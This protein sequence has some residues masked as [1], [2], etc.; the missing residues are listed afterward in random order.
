MPVIEDAYKQ[1]WTTFRYHPVQAAL[2][3]YTGR[4]A[5]IVAGRRSGKT[6]LCRRKLVLQLPIK[7]PW[8]DPRYYFILPTYR[9]AEEVAWEKIKE[10]V[11]PAWIL[12]GGINNTKMTIK[13]VFGSKLLVAGADKPKR[14]EGVPSDFVM[15]DE[16]ADQQPGLFSRTIL[17]M[18]TERSGNC[19]RLGVPKKDGIGRMEFREFYQHG[20]QGLNQIASFHWVSADIL[21]PGEVELARA[22]LDPVEFAEQ[23]EAMWQDLGSSVY[24]NFG[25]VNLRDD[26]DYDPAYEIVVGCDFNVDPMCWTL[27][28]FIDGKLYVFDELFLRDANTPKTMDFLANKFH[29]HTAG[30]KFF[31]DATSKARKTNASRS[32]YVIIKNDARFGNK[33]VI[34]P[35]K[36]PSRRDRYASVNAAF[37]TA[38][39][40]TR[41]YVHTRCKR[42]I[43]DFNAVSYVEGTTDLEDYT[44][45]DLGHMSDALGYEVYGLMPIRVIPTSI[46]TVLSKTG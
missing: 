33:R 35:E 28:Q 25:Q 16:S 7:K 4:F 21:D 41:L 44:G 3:T 22:H 11:P 40:N 36:N 15:I 2:W 26:F 6:D 37:K 19:Y 45:T 27:S 31:G 13:T 9:Q 29:A 42:L 46:P 34:F 24:Y 39:G 17:P 38:D 14:L 12:K 10:L 32:D 23:F 30:W 20:L 8:P 18:L 1:Y 43:N 5:A